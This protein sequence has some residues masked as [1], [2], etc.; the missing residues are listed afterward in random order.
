[1]RGV[2]GAVIRRLRAAWDVSMEGRLSI[3]DGIDI[4]Q[5]LAYATLS[6]TTSVLARPL[7]PLDC[8]GDEC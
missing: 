6:L 3:G 1:M 2:S 7:G 4:L 5:T 8:D